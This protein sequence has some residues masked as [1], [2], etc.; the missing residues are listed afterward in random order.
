M[1]T[2]NPLEQKA[3]SSFIKGIIITAFIAAI[4]IGILI[5][6]LMAT[7]E[8]LTT[9]KQ[10]IGTALVLAND[11]TSGQLLTE[12]DFTS[13]S[14]FKSTLPAGA[15]S[16]ATQLNSYLLEDVDGNKI[17]QVSEITYNGQTFF[18]KTSAIN[19]SIKTLVT[20]AGGQ[21][22]SNGQLA[23]HF[24]S[25]DSVEGEEDAAVTTMKQTF[26]DYKTYTE[27]FKQTSGGYVYKQEDGTLVPIELNENAIV[28]K[29]D[30]QK[31]TIVTSSM[32]S[33]ATEQITD[34]LREIELNMLS[35][36]TTLKD[37]E[38][39][40]IRL[41][42]PSG[43]DY[44]VLSK[45]TVTLI[46]NSDGYMPN[47]IVIK[48]T[49]AELLQLNSAIIETYQM[50]EQGA[51]LY[52]VKYTDPG[53]QGELTTTYVPSKEIL[54]MIQNDPNVVTEAANKILE[55]YQ[56]D[57]TAGVNGG[58]RQMIDSTLSAVEAD[59]RASGISSGVSSEVS[60]IQ[61]TRE[62]YLQNVKDTTTT[63]TTTN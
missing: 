50:L 10:K 39:I 24:N 32:F 19:N 7:N 56:K 17:D 55:Y 9:E 49:E 53:M 5:W 13:V 22:V 29:I 42:L 20:N 47:D 2:L 46:K 61:S 35:L 3:R 25:T 12:T 8:E 34:D 36:P 33:K 1:A 16:T 59:E 38:T 43:A 6:R 37:N 30:M 21:I 60:T 48:G 63:T 57:T 23:I 28:A 11:V 58:G 18:Y 4:A 45:K 40:D 27:V 41:R 31:N 54:V 26:P 44:I 52:A 15:T 51:K 62:E 14:V